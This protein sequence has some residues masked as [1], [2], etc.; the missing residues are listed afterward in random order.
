VAV[1]FDGGVS[2]KM[3]IFPMRSTL[4]LGAVFLAPLAFLAPAQADPAYK[5]GKVIDFFVQDKAAQQTRGLC[6]GSPAECPTPTTPT[7]AP[8]P[9]RFDLLVNFD[10]DSARLT[11]SATENLGEFAKALQ[12]PRL[13]GQ[14]FE[15]DGYTDATGAEEYNQDLSERRA[16]AVVSYLSSQGLAA[17][18]FVAK[19]FGKANPRVPDPYSPENRR[20]ET[21][22]TE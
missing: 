4:A 2:A 1:L 5:A 6:I 15:I 13:K 9:A 17:S 10:F 14:K 19:G 18:Q 3:G 16:N 12:D 21:H 20:V 7:K 8:P 11:K 22:L